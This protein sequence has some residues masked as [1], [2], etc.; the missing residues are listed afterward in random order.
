MIKM[1]YTHCSPPSQAAQR[2]AKL[3]SVQADLQYALDE[4]DQ[5][6]F[7]DKTTLQVRSPSQPVACWLVTPTLKGSSAFESCSPK[8]CLSQHL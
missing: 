5:G 3:Q 1:W 6:G 4:I 2:V 7:T 8:V